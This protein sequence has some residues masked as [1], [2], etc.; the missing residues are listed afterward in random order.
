M[1]LPTSLLWRQAGS[2]SIGLLGRRSGASAWLEPLSGTLAPLTTRLVAD[3]C[4][5]LRLTWALA[6]TVDA[7][8]HLDSQWDSSP[9]HRGANE[10]NRCK[11]V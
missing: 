11:L 8:K 5:G 6:S 2:R 10:V 7:G 9:S 1:S 3:S 4:Q